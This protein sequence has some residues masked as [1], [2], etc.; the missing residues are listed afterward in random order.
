[1]KVEWFRSATVGIYTDSGTRILCDPW[2]TNGAFIGS[3]FHFPKLEGFEFKELVNRKWDALYISHLHADHFDRK[4]VAAIAR[5][6][7]DCLVILPK[8]AHR[9][10]YRAVANCGFE[11]HRILEVE[12]NKSFKLKDFAIKV[13]TADFCDPQVCG[14]SAPCLPISPRE[15]SIDSLALFEA[16]GQRILNAN[17]ALAVQSASKLWPTI[18]TVD[19]LLGHYGGAGPYPQAFVGINND[20]KIFEAKNLA[21][22]FVNR[23][24]DTSVKLKARFVMPYAGQYILGG[25]LSKLNPYR[26]VVRLEEVLDA[27][28]TSTDSTP[29]GLQPFSTFNLTTGES[30]ATWHE[31]SEFEVDQYLKSVE[32]ELFPYQLKE[33]SWENPDELIQSALTSVGREYLARENFRVRDYRITISAGDSSKTIQFDSQDFK[34]LDGNFID[35]LNTTSLDFDPRLLKRLIIRAEGYKG[36]TPY[37]FNQAEI[38]SH[39]QWRRNGE[40]NSITSLLNFMHVSN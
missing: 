35:L 30:E 29:I 32:G 23:L 37:H 36:F 25:T 22:I 12:T 19:L 6:Q 34:I 31:P 40:Y 15:S 20:D 2:I 11:P 9:W 24:L 28:S 8:F 21:G 10:L 16:D 4:L 26:S 17:D 18:G 3:W 5:N 13:F 33:E 1:M 27:I 7:P 38:G 39:I 14:L